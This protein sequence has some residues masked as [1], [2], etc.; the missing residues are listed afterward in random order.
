MQLF[1]TIQY[2]NIHACLYVL[3]TNVFLIPPLLVFYRKITNRLPSD[4][5]SDSFIGDSMLGQTINATLGS[6]TIKFRHDFVERICSNVI[7]RN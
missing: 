2:L 6:D 3:S 4:Q 7:N 5:S 1:R